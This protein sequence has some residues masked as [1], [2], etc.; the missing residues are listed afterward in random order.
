[1]LVR[2]QRLLEADGWFALALAENSNNPRWYVVRAVTARVA[3]N[4]EGALQICLEA[5]ERFPA[6]AP[7]YYQAAI[8]YRTLENRAHATNAIAQALH[9]MNPPNAEYF[10]TAGK[11]YEWTGDAV[12]AVRAFEQ[13]IALSPGHPEALAGLDRLRDEE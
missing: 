1:M 9:Y 11:I 5:I 6:Y 10:V 7:A 2:E 12:K 13:A 4:P 8:L 3:G